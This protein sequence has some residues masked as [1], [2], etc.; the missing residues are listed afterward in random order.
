MT[1]TLNNLE[2]IP[3]NLHGSKLLGFLYPTRFQDEDAV[4]AELLYK[5]CKA[6]LTDLYD[7]HL[8]ENL[9][10]TEDERQI[11]LSRK[12][13]DSQNIEVKSRCHDV[14]CRFESDKR[15]IKSTT[16][17]YYLSAYRIIGDVELLVRS[18]TIRDIKVINNDTYLNEILFTIQEQDIY[19]FWINKLIIAL[20]KSYSNDQLVALSDY[21]LLRKTKCKTNHA[22][23]KERGFAEALYSLGVV[24]KDEL[25]KEQALSYENEADYTNDNKQAGT[26]YP[27]IVDI[28]QKAYNEIFQIKDKE[29]EILDR[30]KNKLIHEKARF[31]EMLSSYGVSMKTSISDEFVS[32]VEE[33]AAHISL[34]HFFDTIDLL[35][36]IP[37]PSL[38]KINSFVAADQETAPFSSKYMGQSQ[39][40]SKGNNI[41][42]AGSD[43]VLTTRAYTHYR[44]CTL[45]FLWSVMKIHQWSEISSN[46]MSVYHYLRN[47]K[48]DYVN[49]ENTIFWAKGIAHGL[50][51]DFISASH[52]L[53]PQLEHT[54]HNI[55]EIK[56][57][58][59][60]TLENK[61]QEN[62]TLGK[63]LPLLKGVFKEEV[64][65]EIESFLQNG[66]D[67]N[68]R[69]NLS[70]GL[71]MPFEIEK[72]GIYLWWVCLKVYFGK[73]IF[74][75]ADNCR[76]SVFEG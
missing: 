42:E 28:Y 52:I 9:V 76:T 11:V 34:G 7:E 53:M 8:I 62:L 56:H 12:W 48:P 55:A 23:D 24:S 21:I 64:L 25:H 1:H 4:A 22:Y 19:P 39:L 18:V 35:R 50:N 5:I 3:E 59:L 20:K 72:Y 58:T 51:G 63:I 30:I 60:T 6:K 27:D 32:R 37:F 73:E 66:I 33:C 14:L 38:E 40:D 67:V 54:L 41:G 45:Y 57:G 71:F 68:F 49:D 36:Q 61:R 2:D 17:N 74:I 10:L 46:E 16:S 43:Y 75:E 15:S 44:Q 69:N 13:I 47:D 65:S 31:M 29:P 26:F 70:H